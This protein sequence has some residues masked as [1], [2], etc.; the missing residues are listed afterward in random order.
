MLP[1]MRRSSCERGG[2][3][4]IDRAWCASWQST[5]LLPEATPNHDPWV[6]RE[7]ATTRRIKAR[8]KENDCRGVFLPDAR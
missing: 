2:S 6:E 3:T 1:T 8:F 4:T 5:F 7:G